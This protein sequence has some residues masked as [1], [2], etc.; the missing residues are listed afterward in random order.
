MPERLKNAFFNNPCFDGADLPY[1]EDIDIASTLEA[2][3]GFL[4]NNS[5]T[6]FA[7]ECLRLNPNMRPT[8]ED[9]MN[10]DYFNEFREWF[11]D[12]I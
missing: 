2:K 8:C 4:K 6:S 9:L 10:H 7:R 5:A 3:L 1:I 12:E 11:D